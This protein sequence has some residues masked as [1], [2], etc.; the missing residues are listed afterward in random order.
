MFELSIYD[1]F[2]DAAMLLAAAGLVIAVVPAL[3]RR[4][5][6]WAAWGLT[7]AAYL[8]T[9]IGGVSWILTVATMTGGPSIST[10]VTEPLAAVALGFF[11][12]AAVA[13][14]LA[15]VPA[16]RRRRGLVA[17][18]GSGIGSLLMVTL[19]GVLGV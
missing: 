16:L 3:R 11:V 19:V 17:A 12:L 18:W 15:V 9:A 1:L 6:V 4:R 5:D 14:T 13:I 7:V 10:F 8:L 2:V